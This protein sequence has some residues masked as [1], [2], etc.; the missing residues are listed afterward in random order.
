MNTLLN[1]IFQENGIILS[2]GNSYKQQYR[3]SNQ[4]EMEMLDSTVKE[5]GLSTEQEFEFWDKIKRFAKNAAVA[6]MTKTA[7]PQDVEHDKRINEKHQITV[8]TDEGN[9]DKSSLKSARE[10]SIMQEIF[11]EADEKTN[12]R[13]Y[14]SE[15]YDT[16]E[17]NIDERGIR[18]K[19]RRNSYGATHTNRPYPDEK[20]R[21]IHERNANKSSANAPKLRK[22]FN[23]YIFGLLNRLGKNVPRK[24]IL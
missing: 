7:D 12:D 8:L 11:M 22:V 21:P 24:K 17:Y 16:R 18:R 1:E 6:I 19:K 5:F 14:L 4:E 15:D 13:E 9:K 20:I 10:L 2:N 3:A 23:K